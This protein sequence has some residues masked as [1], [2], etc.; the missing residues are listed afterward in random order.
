[1][2]YEWSK[3][4]LDDTDAS[5]ASYQNPEYT[6]DDFEVCQGEEFG[7]WPNEVV[8]ISL[9]DNNDNTPSCSKPTPCDAQAPQPT[10]ATMSKR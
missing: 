4:L 1:M 9:T 5:W 3:R 2:T 6:Y 8:P 10:L 7:G